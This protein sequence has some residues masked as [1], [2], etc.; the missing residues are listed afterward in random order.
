M[1]NINLAQEEKQKFYDEFITFFKEERDEDIGVI[2]A[3]LFLNFFIETL[4][5]SI[6]NKGIE[7]TQNKIKDKLEE[8]DF[9]LEEL[10]K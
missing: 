8:I 10:K 6:Y 7:T 9:E 2:Q 3:E 4:G 5:T 1:I